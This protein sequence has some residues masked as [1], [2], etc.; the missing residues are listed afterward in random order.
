MERHRSSLRVR[1]DGTVVV[2]RKRGDEDIETRRLKFQQPPSLAFQFFRTLSPSPIVFQVYRFSEP[3]PNF[4]QSPPFGC[5]KVFGAP[6]SISSSLLVILTE[7]SLSDLF[8]T[9]DGI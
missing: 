4:F 6:P 8:K 7:L 9:G 1:L 2:V 5:L 3:L